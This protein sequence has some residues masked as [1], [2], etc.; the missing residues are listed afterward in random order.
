M[1]VSYKTALEEN[2]AINYSQRIASKHHY[3][4]VS[5]CRKRGT[6]NVSMM[7]MYPLL[8]TAMRCYIYGKSII[9]HFLLICIKQYGNALSQ[10]NWN[11]AV[12]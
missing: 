11:E 7:T 3:V 6:V 2:E 5:A 9:M 12:P 10:R 8:L 4:Y 1:N